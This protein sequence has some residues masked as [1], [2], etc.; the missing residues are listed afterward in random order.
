MANTNHQILTW[1][2]DHNCT[3]LWDKPTFIT[4]I[5]Y[6]THFNKYQNTNPWHDASSVI[7]W[8]KMLRWKKYFIDIYGICCYCYFTAM[9]ITTRDAV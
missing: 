6:N 3:F 7:V 2:Y 4:I 8:N 1:H 5:L 9:D